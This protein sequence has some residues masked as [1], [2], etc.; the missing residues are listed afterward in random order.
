VRGGGV[1]SNGER[2]SPRHRASRYCRNRLRC[3]AG[4][5]ATAGIAASAGCLNRFEESG[6]DAGKEECIPRNAGESR[7]WG[8]RIPGKCASSS[9]RA[10]RREGQRGRNI[11]LELNRPIRGVA[12]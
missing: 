9:G 3:V 2:R 7:T 4:A 8:V 1:K 11:Q 10:R 5:I 6:A 12:R